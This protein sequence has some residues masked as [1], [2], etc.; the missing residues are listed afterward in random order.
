MPQAVKNA[1]RILRREEVMTFSGLKRTQL[2]EHIARGEFPAPIKL[3]ESGR[4]VGW[5][6]SELHEWLVRRVAQRDKAR[7]GGAA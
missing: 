6:E 1:T 4:A 3:T 2:K 5:L 7:A